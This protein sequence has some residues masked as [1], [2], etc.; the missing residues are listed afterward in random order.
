MEV[1]GGTFRFDHRVIDSEQSINRA[2]LAHL[3]GE[4][5]LGI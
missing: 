2:V 3:Y 1:E 5:T 4:S